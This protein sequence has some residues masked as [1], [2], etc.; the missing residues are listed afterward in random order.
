MH[1][2]CLSKIVFK[3]IILPYYSSYEG[4]N[5]KL[6]LTYGYVPLQQISVADTTSTKLSI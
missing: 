6:L 2:G 5:K 1:T 4:I 3:L